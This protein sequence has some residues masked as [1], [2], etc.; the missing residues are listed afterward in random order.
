MTTAGGLKRHRTAAAADYN[1]SIATSDYVIAVT[2]TGADRAVTI[3]TEDVNSGSTDNPRVFIV[4]DEGGGAGA[5]NIT[6]SLESGNIDGA[7]TA[8]ISTNYNSVSIYL[9][10]TNGF[11]F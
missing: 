2:S 11:I 10:G 1:P 9:D 7:A 5:N 4:K 6:V 3:S 8:V